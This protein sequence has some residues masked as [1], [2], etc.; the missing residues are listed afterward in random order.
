MLCLSTERPSTT[1]SILHFP[2]KCICSA[3]FITSPHKSHF[4]EPWILNIIA[5]RVQVF[6]SLA[7]T[8]CFFSPFQLSGFFCLS[9]SHFCMNLNMFIYRRDCEKNFKV[10]E[11]SCLKILFKLLT[12]LCDIST[13]VE[14]GK[15]NTSIHLKR[16]YRLTLPSSLLET[17]PSLNSPSQTA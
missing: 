17:Y 8:G 10:A 4:E 13:L 7:E 12:V 5:Q 9:W 15:E 11:S 3:P 16:N 6:L 14:L 2:P 1:A